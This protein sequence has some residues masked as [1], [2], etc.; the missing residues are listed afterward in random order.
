[1]NNIINLTDSYKFSHFNQYPKGTEI[2]HSYM[3][4][5]GGEYDEL[6]FF[7]L[8]YY[9]DKYLSKTITIED[10][11]KAE[12]L[13][14]EHGVPFNKEG[15]LRLVGQKIK[16]VAIVKSIEEGAIFKPHQPI[17]TIENKYPEDYWLVGHLETLL[18]KLWYPI[19]IATKSYHVKKMLK[20]YWDKTS[21]NPEG[22]DFA[23]HNFGDRGSS[24]VESAAIG[25]LAHLTQFKGTDN[26]NSLTL[27][28]EFYDGKYQGF[29]IPATEHSTVTS[30]GRDNEFQMI[31][32]Y[33][34]TYKDSPIIACVLDSYDIFKAVDFVTSG[35]MKEKIESDDYPIF[36]IRPDSGNPIE[37]IE[38]IT[39]IMIKNDISFSVNSKGYIVFD[40]YRIIWGDGITPKQID[41]ILDHFCNTGVEER[42]SAENFAFGSGGDLMQNITRDTCRFAIKCSAIRVDDEWKDVYKDPITDSGKKSLAGRQVIGES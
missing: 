20:G 7:G 12:S 21:D 1:M 8:K 42:Y 40:K 31:E 4:S 10:I 26:F 11:K 19:T 27:G 24:S 41:K 6:V 13:T 33:L 3:S 16:D 34:E 17:L 28:N 2:I 30:W 5:R 32:S 18:M 38:N 22:I 35:N 29:S 37:V 39:K 15:W 36:V 25:G 23:Y 14:K 9:V